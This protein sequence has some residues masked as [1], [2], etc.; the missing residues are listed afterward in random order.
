MDDGRAITQVAIRH[1]HVFCSLGGGA[2]GFNR[3]QARVGSLQARMHCVGGIDVDAG[4]LGCFER[5]TG[6]QGTHRDLF[7]REQ[8]IAFHS[9]EPPSDWREA[10]P[11]DIRRAF[12]TKKPHIVFMS[13][14]CKGFSGLLPQSKAGSAKYLALNELALRGV[15]LTLEAYA[16]DPV[17]LI[18]LENVPRIAQRGRHL[19][20]QIESLLAQHGYASRE[21]THDCGEIGGLAQTRKRFLLVARHIA[22][23]PPHLY[24]PP[25]HRLRAIGSVLE[26]L[27]LPEDPRAGAM[28]RL[29]RLKWETWVRLALIP[30]GG[31]WRALQNLPFREFAIE[32]LR[33]WNQG[34]LGVRRW[35]ET[36]GAV[37]GRTAPSNGAFSI[38]DPRVASEWGDYKAYGI[39]TWD[40]PSGTVSGAAA[41]GSGTYSVADPRAHGASERFRNVYRVV[42]WQDPSGAVTSGHGPS[43]G[44][45]AVADPRQCGKQQDGQFQTAGHFGVEPWDATSRAVLGSAKHDNGRWSIADPRLAGWNAG[46]HKSKFAVRRWEDNSTCV[47]GTVDVQSGA[48]SVADPRVDAMY[49]HGLRVTP[50]EHST[51][52]ITASRSPG[53]GAAVVADPRIPVVG[54]RMDPPPLI[55]SLD[56]TWHRPLTTL[57]LAALQSFPVEDAC[58]WLLTKSHTQA[59]EWIGNAVPPEAVVKTLLLLAALL[60]ADTITFPSISMQSHTSICYATATEC[61]RLP[62]T[63]QCDG[64]LLIAFCV[65][66]RIFADGFEVKK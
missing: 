22:Q 34:V 59:R 42:R 31:D 2:S 16:D 40:Q 57:E 52:T 50:W 21:T 24:E 39:R 35:D 4:S 5:L 61:R 47:T 65:P 33:E 60:P 12:G 29:P 45:I 1:A 7:S 37:C 49:G 32:P 19:L 6:A 25:K 48:I 28:H 18:L 23:V 63:W 44:G 14:P 66:D 56:N 9:K 58:P 20:D 15:W 54:E 46:T 30:A 55:V 41:P 3:G 64:E 17:D 13:P 62:P 36:S 43:S 11:A 10:T 38:A 26:T 8:Y 27:P 51:G 53:S